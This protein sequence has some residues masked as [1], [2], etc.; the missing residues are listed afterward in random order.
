MGRW[1]RS[2]SMPPRELAAYWQDGSR[3]WR[4]HERHSIDSPTTK[5]WWAISVSTSSTSVAKGPNPFPLILT[6]GYPDSFYRFSK[7]IPLLTDP[8]SFGGQAEDAP[9]SGPGSAGATAHQPPGVGTVFRVNDLWAQLMTEMLG[10][11]YT[12]EPTAETGAARSRSNSRVVVPTRSWLSTSPMFIRAYPAKACGDPSPAEKKLFTH[13]EEW[14]Q[15]EGAYALI[16]SGK[17]AKMSLKG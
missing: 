2:A 10:Y 7:L 4:R 11:E 6:H 8:A 3:D 5:R 9:R 15:K 14:L 16:Q 13:N 1:S 12:L 17:A